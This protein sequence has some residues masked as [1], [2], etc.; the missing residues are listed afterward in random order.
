MQLRPQK[1]VY[2]VQDDPNDDSS[3]LEAP[4][5]ESGS[6]DNEVLAGE[7]EQQSSDDEL[8][9]I[10]E[11]QKKAKKDFKK[12]FRSY[13]DSKRKVKEIKKARAGPSSYYP[14]VA[15]PPDNVSAS[16][17][18]QPTVKPF[19]YDHK[20][21]NKKKGD[22]RGSK[23]PRKE[24]ANLTQSEFVENFSYMVEECHAISMDSQLNELDI[25]L[26][27][28]PQG[29][30]IVDTGCTTSVIG[31]QTAATLST[32]LQQHG[33]PAPQEVALPAVELKGFNG[34]SEQTTKGLRWTVCLG[35]LQGNI[36]TY[37]VPGMTPFLL[38]RRVL[39]G[40]EAVLDLHHRTITCKK[41]GMDQVPL[42]QASNGH[43]L[44]PL[45]AIDGELDVAQCE[46]T[47]EPNQDDPPP[48]NHLADEVEVPCNLPC[49]D[50]PSRTRSQPVKITPLDQK[51]AFQTV[52]K[53]TKNGVIDLKTHSKAL[54][55][56]FG[57]S[58]EP[59]VHAA[60]AYRPKKERVP[61]GAD[62]QEF[63]CSVA[64]LEL[65][66]KFAISPWRNRTA[67]IDR[68]P[69]IAM[70]T[71]IF[72]FRLPEPSPDVSNAC[73][74]PTEPSCYCCSACD[75]SPIQ[76]ECHGLDVEE[77]YNENMDW[78]DL[79]SK[80]DV[81]KK[82]QEMLMR[83]IQSMRKASSRMVLSRMASQPNQVK[84]EL[85]KW[86]G[87]QAYKLDKK[88]GLVEVFTGQAPLSDMFE[89]TTGSQAIRLGLDYGQDFTKLHDRRCL[90]LL[91]AW[92]RPD[93]LWF[94]FPCKYWGQ[95]TH[96]NMAKE[97]ST[98]QMIVEQQNIAR[99]YLHNVSEAWHLQCL[100]G[101]QAHAENPLS[102]LA[103]AEL[104]LENALEV[105]IDQ[106]A[107]GLRSPK[108]DQ[109]VLKPTR[110]VTS[111]SDL[112]SG[113]LK[114]RC[115]GRHEHAHLEGKFKGYNLTSW[116]ETYPKKFCRIMVGLMSQQAPVSKHK[117]VEDILAEEHDELEELDQPQE[118]VGQDSEGAVA[119][120]GDDL[121]M[122][123]ARALVHKVHI[124]T[125]H[126]SPE[127]MTRL[128]L[129]C[130]SSQAIR[131][132][133]KEFRCSVC[134][135]LKPPPSR[136][137][138]TIAHTESPNEVVGVDY[139]Q[140]ELTREDQ[141]GQNRTV[142]CN[143]LTCVD[144]ATDFCQ[145][146]VVQPGPHGLSKAF[147]QVWSRPFGVP[148]TVYM[149]P[150]HRT[151]SHDFQRY[152]VR[153]NIQLLHAAAEAHWQLGKVEVAN[154]VLRSMAQHVWRSGV[155]AS[156]EEVIETCAG[157]RN[158]QLRK[159]G[160]SPVQWFLGREPRHTGSLADVEEQL[161]PATQSQILDDPT[162]A[163]KVRLRDQAAKAFL[164]EHAK[165][166]WRRAVAG[167]NRP[168][169]GPFVQGQL[170]YMFRRQ[171]KGTARGMLVTRQ[172]AWLGPGRIIGTESSR[173][174]VIPR[175]IW[176]SYNGFLYRCAP[177]GLR[178]MP[179]DETVFRKLSKSLTVGKLSP[180]ME[181]AESHLRHNAGQFIDLV[182]SIPQD[183]DFELKEDM[184]VEPEAP[185]P[186]S[187]G[188]PR[189]V[190]RRFYRSPEYWEQRAAGMPPAGALQEGPRP[191]MVHLAPDDDDLMSEPIDEPEEKRRRVAINSD[192]DE[193]EY[194]PESPLREPVADEP[195]IDQPQINP[196]DSNLLPEAAGTVPADS[197]ETTDVPMIEQHAGANERA[198][199]TQVPD[200]GDELQV[201]A[202]P[203][204]P[205]AD[206]KTQRAE[207]VF[208]VSMDVLAT[209]IT[210]DPLCLWE[211]LDECFEV[212]PKAKQ[213]K[214]EVSFRNLSPHEKKLFEGAMQKE[215]NS[216]IENRVTSLCKSKGVSTDRIIRARWVLTWKKSSDP[217]DRN[218][219][220]KA[221]LVLVGWQD[222]ELGRIQTD[223]P[224]LR[225][226][227]KHMILSI[228]ASRKWRIW[229]ADIKTA[230]LSGD[231]SQRNIYF[232]P[233]SEIKTWMNLS[234]DDLFRLEK[235]AYGLA[236]APRAWYLRLTRELSEV[237]LHA[238]KLDPCLYTLRK[239]GKLVGLC[240]IHVD[241]LIGAGTKEM[242]EVLDRLKKKLPFGDYRTHTIRY[243]GIE[244]RQNPKTF[245][246]EVGQEAYID[247][248]E[249]IPTKTMGNA[250]TPIK[251]PTLM[252]TCAGQLAWVA[253]ATRPDQAFLAS[254]LQ[255]I[256]DKG[257]VSHIQLFNKAVREMKQRKVCLHFPPGIELENIR[258]LCISDAGWGTRA[259]G[260]SQGGYLLC[261]T[262]PQMLER[263]RAVC[264][265]IDWQSKKLRRVVRSSVAA[266]TLAGQNGLDG[267]EAFQAL[268]DETLF[269][270]S[271]KE[272][273]N[274]IPIHPAALV[275]DSKGFFDAVTRSCCSQAI[276]QE[277]R[278]QIDYSIAKETTQKQNI[279]VFW[280]NNLRMSADCL[281]K[282]KGDTA[283]LFEI[284]EN[285]T[286]EITICSQSGKKQKQSEQ[287]AQSPQ[288]DA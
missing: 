42:R 3:S 184:D 46:D 211:V 150:D 76:P 82:S 41:H 73:Q 208:E 165:D 176:V 93:H 52:V 65:C 277:R 33:Y 217:D 142:I 168:M 134:D 101:G 163:A 79:D 246:I 186:H 156:P 260:E 178:P 155:D 51:R 22:G 149:D 80:Q 242:D 283:P 122:K 137:K 218:K 189:K 16:G 83:S 50:K 204:A 99:R 100:L 15:M 253:N 96:L 11:I 129:R 263:K 247:A 169:R 265:L 200:D 287:N 258:I 256:Q 244:I 88:V 12:S 10:Y 120:P 203:S 187:E 78:V 214:V 108:T 105:R 243:T 57:V 95:W 53:N 133:I 68:R 74:E 61:P 234:N 8:A 206:R 85:R 6:D 121:E 1:Q 224:T 166:T 123:R 158:E 188:G 154:R 179:E 190:R 160:F 4:L 238:S 97:E 274:K 31:E 220:P 75:S 17:S 191:E 86:L 72:A 116:A 250:S 146:I 111:M 282:L 64:S 180:E 37:V 135:E 216:W 207:Q 227:T 232:R 102:F 201:T 39:E 28:I 248:L 193:H 213:R 24:E 113:L 241:D 199:N 162:F 273:R 69:V 9:E 171:G 92:C 161:N 192:V 114:F 181:Q 173:D 104:S 228:C 45:C 77:L 87:S 196:D 21:S 106:C 143:V 148:K 47:N 170:V 132:A 127:L 270:T 174:S 38:S 94:S 124:N 276:S 26:A 239:N 177:E 48:A 29:F 183:D 119:V 240:G 284:L 36:T 210:S 225:K 269:G 215:W 278:L 182:P 58:K 140:V 60:V 267:I 107:L 27:S 202:Q 245:A 285:G 118:Q 281:T 40:M 32:F 90:L 209:D 280:V 288:E 261:L 103:W 251:D 259:N 221:R 264:W 20:D 254:F 35:K 34:K 115:D 56:I 153:H 157:I 152:M 130:Q 205:S 159:H 262:V 128:A 195:Q 25:Y 30:A 223:S 141:R 271:P 268:W 14:V 219:T 126:S 272:F 7:H 233:P 167:R 49:K 198:V 43:F 44:L 229:G 125:G 257:N 279:L 255:G 226:E 147:H 144:L 164:D 63:Q 151:I 89:K 266:E 109:P 66:G 230:F 139:V 59:I 110:I 112:A 117:H 62:K 222:P 136:R 13:K 84:S 175:L 172:G 81:P 5:T 71:A 98:R 286:Y 145:Q 138:A 131:R 2:A 275:L 236:E 185:D 194:E 197:A 249:Q 18:Q 212:T 23:P 67:S 54:E 231:P 91:I 252:R 55:I 19:K 237:G 235:A 70:N